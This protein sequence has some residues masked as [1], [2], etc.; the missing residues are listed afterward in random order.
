MLTTTRSPRCTGPTHQFKV[1]L[2]QVAH[3]RHEG[4]PITALAR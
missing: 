2:V 4:Y 3:G 1:T